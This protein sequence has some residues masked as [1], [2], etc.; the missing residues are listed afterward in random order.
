MRTRIDTVPSMTTA[1]T[2]TIQ[3][4]KLDVW[5][6]GA[7]PDEPLDVEDELVAAVRRASELR[8]GL[9]VTSEQVC[10]Q[11]PDPYPRFWPVSDLEWD[12]RSIAQVLR[13]LADHGRL[14]RCGMWSD[15][16]G[17]PPMQHWSPPPN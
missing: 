14:F 4:G 9:A 12:L 6:L 1:R 16:T 3:D 5:L 10:A 13:H 17:K 15:R 2:G 8:N 11:L 7:A